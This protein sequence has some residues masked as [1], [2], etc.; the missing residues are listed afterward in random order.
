MKQRLATALKIFPIAPWSETI[1][2]AKQK[3]QDR[4]DNANIS[5]LV[6]AVYNWWPP[7]CNELN[8][9]LAWIKLGRPRTKWNEH[10]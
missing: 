1:A 7:D 9:Q 5:P 8:L 6:G 10:L 4:L 2:K 3:L